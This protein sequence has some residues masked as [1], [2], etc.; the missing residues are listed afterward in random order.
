[1]GILETQIAAQIEGNNGV[2]L[3]LLGEGNKAPPFL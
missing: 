1:M 2:G 3:F